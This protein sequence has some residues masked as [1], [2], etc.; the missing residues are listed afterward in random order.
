MSE[1][2]LTLYDIETTL[3]ALTD[4]STFEDL[5]PELREAYEAALAIAIQESL[6]KRDAIGFRLFELGKEAKLAATNAQ[7]H[8]DAAALFTA[9]MRRFEAAAD[10]LREYVL[11]VMRALPKSAKGGPRKLEGKASTLKAC[12]VPA[13]VEFTDEALVPLEFKSV[14]VTMPALAWQTLV[15]D[16][17]VYNLLGGGRPQWSTSKAAVKAALQNG[18]DVPGAKLID[19][20]LRLVVE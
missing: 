15:E 19:D 10:R 17:N 13:S 11:S 9:R 16:V 2:K 12:A 7:I 6:E 5:A 18:R 8:A 20:K 14:T 3:V 1:K 4:I